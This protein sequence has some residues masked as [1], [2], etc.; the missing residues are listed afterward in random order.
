MLLLLRTENL[1]SPFG[2]PFLTFFFGE[3]G[4]VLGLGRCFRHLFCWLLILV[5]TT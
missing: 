4:S 1:Y 5:L 3:A 2:E